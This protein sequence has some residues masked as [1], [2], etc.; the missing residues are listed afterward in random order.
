VF[1]EQR[2]SSELGDRDVYGPLENWFLAELVGQETTNSQAGM[3]HGARGL[4][5]HGVLG[6]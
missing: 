1:N 6:D 2:I 5:F 3:G 4:C